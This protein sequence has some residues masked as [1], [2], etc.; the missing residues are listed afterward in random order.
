MIQGQ[1]YLK[2]NGPRGVKC[3]DRRRRHLNEEYLRSEHHR[4][5]APRRK[6]DGESLMEEDGEKQE[7]MDAMSATKKAS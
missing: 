7:A 4:T 6:D 1:S 2:D 5:S 3:D